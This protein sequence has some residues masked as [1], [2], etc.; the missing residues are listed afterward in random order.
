MSLLLEANGVAI[1]IEKTPIMDLA[2]LLIKL[3]DFQQKYITPEITE[4]SKPILQNT[5]IKTCQLSFL[6]IAT[7]TI[8]GH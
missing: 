7:T 1:K 6:R 2:G 5:P 3:P 8:V 4:D